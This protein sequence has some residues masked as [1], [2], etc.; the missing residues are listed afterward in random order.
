MVN[1]VTLKLLGLLAKNLRKHFKDEA[2]VW[3]KIVIDKFKEKSVVITQC[4]LTLKDF[5]YSITPDDIMDDLKEIADPKNKKITVVTNTFTWL[6]DYLKKNPDKVVLIGSKLIGIL[7]KQTENGDTSIRNSSF[8][9]LGL[10]KALSKNRWAKEMGE[11][12]SKKLKKVDEFAEKVLKEQKAGE[13][14]TASAKENLVKKDTAKATN[15]SQQSPQTKK[16]LDQ[17]PSRKFEKSES[18]DS[19]EHVPVKPA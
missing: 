13:N 17:K 10:L 8:E 12:D 9:I 4:H 5:E 6:M 19:E 18:E 7:V 11:I 3:A 15:I 2:K 14:A 1:I 16:I